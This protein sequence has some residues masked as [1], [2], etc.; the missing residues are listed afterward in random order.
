MDYNFDQNII[1]HILCLEQ[2]W[3]LHHLLDYFSFDQIFKAT[4]KLGTMKAIDLKII[5][6]E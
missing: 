4:S 5:N 2:A 3:W 6:G 1:F